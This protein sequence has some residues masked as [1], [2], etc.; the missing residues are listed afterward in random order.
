MDKI[1]TKQKPVIFVS[2]AMVGLAFFAAFSGSNLSLPKLGA[3]KAQVMIGQVSMEVEIAATPEERAKG[4]SGRQSLKE[5]SGMLFN[6]P[7]YQARDF[8]MK[9]MGFPLDIIWISGGKIVGIEKNVQPEGDTPQKR[10]YS[11]GPVNQVLEVNAGW[12]DKNGI[13]V[14]QT[15]SLIEVDKNL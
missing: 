14:G 5:D 15:F 3:E 7:D 1:Y 13:I 11:P 12:C 10:Y 4:L 2:A 8:W 9:D 6:F